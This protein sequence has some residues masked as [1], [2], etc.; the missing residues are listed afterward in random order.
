MW[1]TVGLGLGTTGTLFRLLLLLHILCAVA[2]F[3]TLALS[4]LRQWRARQRGGEVE[5]LELEDDAFV[6]RVAE[7]LIYAVL[8]LGLLVSLTS[9]SEWPLSQSWL[10]LS[11]LLYLV[12]LGLLHG[13]VHRAEAEYR[14]RLRRVNAGS[15]DDAVDPAELAALDRLE[16]RLRWGWGGFNLLFVVILYLM[17][18]TPGHAR[19]A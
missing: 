9:Q 4:G 18:F 17:V 8:A 14:L 10:S 15:V 13:V 5:Q 1:A 3:G 16:R 19:V 6:T 12:E 11:M 7:Y 2:G